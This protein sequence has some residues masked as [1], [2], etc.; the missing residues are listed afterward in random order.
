[1]T[2]RLTSRCVNERETEREGER[3][4]Y[5]GVVHV[6]QR[7]EQ[8]REAVARDAA[9]DQQVRERH[10]AHAVHAQDALRWWVRHHGAAQ[11]RE[12]VRHVRR[13]VAVEEHLRV[14]R[15]RGLYR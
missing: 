12:Q 2:Q 9:V 6:A 7:V 13:R 14:W 11:R 15:V 10:P 1:V 8:Q 3:D 4:L 5:L